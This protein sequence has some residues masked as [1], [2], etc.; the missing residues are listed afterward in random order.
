[1]LTGLERREVV[2]RFYN[3][4][5]PETVSVSGRAV[6]LRPGTS[7]VVALDETFYG[8]YH[9]SP[10][11]L[12]PEPVICD[13]GANIGFTMLDYRLSYP[14]ARIVGVE[15]DP[16]NAALA[17]VNSGEILTAAINDLA[18]TVVYDRS[19]EAYAFSIGAGE[20]VAQ[21]ITIDQAYEH[22]SLS[23]V[24]LLK[25][26]IE[27]AEEAVLSA[28]GGWVDRTD[29]ILV[30][31]HPPYDVDACIRALRGLGFEAVRDDRHWSAVAGSR[32]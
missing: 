7:D 15:L 18:G 31:V 2:R 16:E 13:L 12:P 24:D 27:G 17:E 26:D 1:M 11:E 9:R 14:D 28:G 30:E 19:A 32:I 3:P 22:F 20:S 21:A 6:T 4:G 5:V 29:R 10:W 8:G 25:M 23:R